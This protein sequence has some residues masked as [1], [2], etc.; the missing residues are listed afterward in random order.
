MIAIDEAD[1]YKNN[2]Q[3]VKDFID[4]RFA[5]YEILFGYD[6]PLSNYYSILGGNKYWPM[7]VIVDQQGFISFVDEGG[8]T[9]A[10]LEAEIVKLLG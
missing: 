3:M 4:N 5:G 8:L 1:E 9:Y 2:P 6:D 10:E 7:T